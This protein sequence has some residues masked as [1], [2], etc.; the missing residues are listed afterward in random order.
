MGPLLSFRNKPRSFSLDIVDK[1]NRLAYVSKDVLLFQLTLF[2]HCVLVTNA[3]KNRNSFRVGFMPDSRLSNLL[4]KILQDFGGFVGLSP[5]FSGA[6]K[7]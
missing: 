1:G 7:K 4:I 5:K 2:S 6:V 3:L